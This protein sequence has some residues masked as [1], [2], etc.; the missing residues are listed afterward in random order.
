M[1]VKSLSKNNNY[2]YLKAQDL[3]ANVYRSKEKWL[4]SENFPDFAQ[5]L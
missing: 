1:I 2:K 4:L 3:S 5:Q